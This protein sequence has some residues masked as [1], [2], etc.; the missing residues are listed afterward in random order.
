M[1]F[2]GFTNLLSAVTSLLL[3]QLMHRD[4]A[5]SFVVDLSD[6]AEVAVSSLAW[7]IGYH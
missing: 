2:P 6:F 1:T 4:I 7:T 3:V 5:S